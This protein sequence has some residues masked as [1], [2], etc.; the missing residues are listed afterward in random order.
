M[1]QFY[2]LFIFLYWNLMII[3]PNEEYLLIGDFY[4]VNQVAR[5]CIIK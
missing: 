1:S 3:W 5:L 2:Y 4:V